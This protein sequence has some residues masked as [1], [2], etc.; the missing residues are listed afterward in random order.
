MNLKRSHVS[1]THTDADV[2]TTLQ[3]AEESMRATFDARARG[4][5]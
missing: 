1:L 3:I 2:D 5:F 4:E